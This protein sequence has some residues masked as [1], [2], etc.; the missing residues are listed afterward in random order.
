MN[1]TS[2]SVGERC[3]TSTNDLT[4][5]RAGGNKRKVY[6]SKHHAIYIY[7][8]DQTTSRDKRVVC[9]DVITTQQY[10]IA[11]FFLQAIKLPIGVPRYKVTQRTDNESTVESIGF[12]YSE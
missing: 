2:W 11:I 4:Q 10:S 7:M 9:D 6:M 3:W 5:G 12:C 1:S 8:K